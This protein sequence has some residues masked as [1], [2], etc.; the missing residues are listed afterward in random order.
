[1]PKIRPSTNTSSVVP[2]QF[3][4]QV[5]REWPMCGTRAT[6][7]QSSRGADIT[8]QLQHS[9]LIDPEGTS[10]SFQPSAAAVTVL[11]WH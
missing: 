2:H 3:Q 5:I 8:N 1:M 10:E 6:A 7:F 4:S 11:K 9:L